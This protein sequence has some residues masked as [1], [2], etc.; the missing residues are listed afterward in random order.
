MLK[1]DPEAATILRILGG[2]AIDLRYVDDSRDLRDIRAWLT[3]RTDG[4]PDPVRSLVDA[5]LGVA[6]GG[7]TAGRI[8]SDVER[9]EVLRAVV[10]FVADQWV[11]FLA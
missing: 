5:A 7:T 11:R 4:A 1:G 2:R 3:R 10:R 6:R 8:G 9:A